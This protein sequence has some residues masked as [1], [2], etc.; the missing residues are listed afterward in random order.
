M[1]TVDEATEYIKQWITDE[2]GIANPGEALVQ[3]TFKEIDV[4]KDGFIDK[5]ELEN[6]MRETKI[7]RM[8]ESESDQGAQMGDTGADLVQ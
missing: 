2:Y 5:V 6:H 3:N 4:N 1:L 7:A 8:M